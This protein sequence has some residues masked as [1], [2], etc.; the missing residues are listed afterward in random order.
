M[1]VLR[2]QGRRD[3]GRVAV[4]GQM[5]GGLVGLDLATVSTLSLEDREGPI[6]RSDFI[7]CLLFEHASSTS[8][9]ARPAL[10]ADQ[11]TFIADAFE[12]LGYDCLL[13]A[14]EGNP[15]DARFLASRAAE[16]GC[17]GRQNRRFGRADSRARPP[18]RA[19]A[20]AC[21]QEP[22]SGPVA[23]ERRH[24]AGTVSMLLCVGTCGGVPAPCAH[25]TTRVSFT[26]VPES[27]EAWRSSRGTTSG[28]STTP[29][30][31]FCSRSKRAR[32]RLGPFPQPGATTI[33]MRLLS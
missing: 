12:P 31:Y 4:L 17:R 5:P 24:Y 13:D 20:P 27:S 3:R 7:G 29:S 28:G 11:T 6:E 10:A 16:E 2:C 1:W 21:I 30:L 23:L 22:L 14:C 26:P 25:F 32:L 8:D 33:W 9:M 19:E 15:R 18:W